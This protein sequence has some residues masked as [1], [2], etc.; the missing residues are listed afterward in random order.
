[1]VNKNYHIVRIGWQKYIFLCKYSILWQRGFFTSIKSKLKLLIF[2]PCFLRLFLDVFDFFVTCAQ[3]FLIFFYIYST[4]NI[5]S[6]FQH[7]SVKY[8]SFLAKHPKNVLIITFFYIS[9]LFLQFSFLCKK[10]IQKTHKKA[11][12]S[13]KATACQI[14]FCTQI[15]EGI[16]LLFLLPPAF[17]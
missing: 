9:F 8:S 11:D 16:R 2:L 5:F 4:Q 6:L 3:F 10:S 13:P 12:C 15:N 17:R 7:F 1:M 14:F